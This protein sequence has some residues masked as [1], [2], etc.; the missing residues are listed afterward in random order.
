MPIK[1]KKS[2]FKLVW[3]FGSEVLLNFCKGDNDSPEHFLENFIS[4]IP[5]DNNC[6]LF[7]Q[8]MQKDEVTNQIL[9]GVFMPV[10]NSQIE[11]F[12]RDFKKKNPTQM[13]ALCDRIESKYLTH[14]EVEVEQ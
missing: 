5:G 2:M 7:T 1:K 4:S 3:D 10:V 6:Q 8:M 14:V 13:Q 9:E 12:I 11:G